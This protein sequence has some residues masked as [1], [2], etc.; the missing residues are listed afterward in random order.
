MRI[1]NGTLSRQVFTGY[2]VHRSTPRHAR[3]ASPLDVDR[4]DLGSDEGH[5][6]GTRLGNRQPVGRHMLGGQLYWRLQPLR[7]RARATWMS[8]QSY[9][10]TLNAPRSGSRQATH[11]KG[12]KTL[13]D[14]R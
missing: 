2:Q 8:S 6:F 13:T 14:T 5:G 4:A 10:A 12:W 3:T 7:G 11:P 1:I 9:S